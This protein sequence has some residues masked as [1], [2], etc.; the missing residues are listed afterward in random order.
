MHEIRGQP[1][2]AREKPACDARRQTR[3]T[4]KSYSGLNPVSVR[5]E[6]TESSPVSPVYP[7][8]LLC[9]SPGDATVARGVELALANGRPAFP[10]LS[11]STALALGT[12]WPC[13]GPFRG[14]RWGFRGYV[15]ACSRWTAGFQAGAEAGPRPSHRWHRLFTSQAPGKG[16]E[17]QGGTGRVSIRSGLSNMLSFLKTP[18]WP[19]KFI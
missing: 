14:P 3:Q 18:K 11:R 12:V 1:A 5:L 15:H 2:T 9:V 19:G 13:L 17:G 10:Q 16:S 4:Q 6:S 7:L 8:C